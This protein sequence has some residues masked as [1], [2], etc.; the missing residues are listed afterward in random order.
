[1]KFRGFVFV[2]ITL[3]FTCNGKPSIFGDAFSL[4]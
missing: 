1:M 4:C 2:M 3:H